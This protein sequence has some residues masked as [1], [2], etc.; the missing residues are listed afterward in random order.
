M[1]PLSHLYLEEPLLS[2]RASQLFYRLVR[3]LICCRLARDYAEYHASTEDGYTARTGSLHLAANDCFVLDHAGAGMSLQLRTPRG[4]A[5]A[6]VPAC[7][8]EEQVRRPGLFVDRY[9]F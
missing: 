9:S 2:Y 5:T 3:R 1:S 4:R 7:L 6:G 8:G